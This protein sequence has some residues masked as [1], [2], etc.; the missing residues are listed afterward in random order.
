MIQR[1]ATATPEEIPTIVEYLAK[2]F[3]KTAIVN[4]NK[5]TAREIETALE[6][7]SNE[8]EAIV[9]Y[10]REH[11]EF[12]HWDGF[13]KVSGVEAKKLEAKRDRIAFH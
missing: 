4:V 8:A 2:N 3:A 10:R 6:L 7:T 12:K 13:V 1:G 5:A 11:G 9:K